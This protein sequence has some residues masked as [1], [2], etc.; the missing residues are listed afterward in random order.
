MKKQYLL[1]RIILC[2]LTAA[3]FFI[4]TIHEE[5]TTRFFCVVAF[6]AAVLLVS[7]PGE[8]ISRRIIGIGDEIEK[9]SKKVLY[10]VLMMVLVLVLALLAFLIISGELFPSG[11]TGTLSQGLLTLFLAAIAVVIILVPYVMTLVVLLLRKLM[12]KQR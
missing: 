4:A 9:T 5:S 11:N 10:Y 6:S 3:G 2:A 8:R 12:K 7:L 1:A